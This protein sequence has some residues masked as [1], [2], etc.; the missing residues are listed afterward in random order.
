MSANSPLLIPVPRN[1]TA[2]LQ[3]LQ[4]LIAH[5]GHRI[6]CGGVVPACKLENFI[7]KMADRYPILRTTRQRTYDR[8]RGRAIVHLVVYPVVQIG[9]G[10]WR[11]WKPPARRDLDG[12]PTGLAS[13]RPEHLAWWLLSDG[14]EGGLGDARSPD[15]HVA[16]DAM[17]AGHHLCAGEYFLVFATKREPRQ[18]DGRRVWAQT[19]TWT[20]KLLPEVVSEV[21]V[22]VETCCRELTLGA[23]PTSDDHGW[24]LRG[25][26]AAQR[27]RPLFSGVR[28][29][30]IAM[31]RLADRMWVRGASR[32]RR[33]TGHMGGV[34]RV[35]ELRPV[36]EVIKHE[37]PKMTR[38]PVYDPVPRT[39]ADLLGKDRDSVP[40]G[41][42]IRD[43][44]SLLSCSLTDTPQIRAPI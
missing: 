32:E 34:A 6:W 44:D 21:R 24:G 17:T 40:A 37:L 38:I 4:R 7:G 2:L 33:A 10:Q 41:T 16:H 8:S 14:G 29:Q 18:I 1:F 9:C 19:S 22:G 12:A 27:M 3:H 39:I 28:T 26:L 43:R 36:S 42:P 20:F 13:C 15:A 23:E 11:P 25:L 30:V 35:G 31:H 5:E